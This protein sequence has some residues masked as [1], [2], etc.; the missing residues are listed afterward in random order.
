MK[1][2]L[3]ISGSL[4]KNSIS[5]KLIKLVADL[6]K[7]SVEVFEDLQ[8]LPYFNP[9]LEEDP[10][11][12]VTVFRSKLK[13]ADGVLIC[14]PEYIFAL[15]G[16]L[17]NALDWIASSGELVDKPTALIIASTSGEKAYESLS[18]IMETLLAKFEGSS[19]LIKGAGGKFSK[20][21]ELKD[22]ASLEKIYGLAETFSKK[23]KL[24]TASS[25]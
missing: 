15:P 21:G 13:K 25:G 8:E 4:R 7:F 20:E 12:Q 14:S 16:V 6:N 24:P 10:P 3:A 9:D 5:T 1:K 11:D 2:V 18:L 22:Q 17:K 23:L 19:L